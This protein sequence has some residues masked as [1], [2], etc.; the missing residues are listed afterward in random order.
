MPRTKPGPAE[1]APARASNGLMMEVLTLSEAAAYLRLPEADVVRLV[2]EQ[3]LPARRLG[4]EWRF[5]QTA[6]RDRLRSGPGSNKEAWMALAGV[7]K[8]DP[9]VEKEL[10]EIYQRRRQ[11]DAEDEK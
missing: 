4:N 2:K 5:L 1:P 8:D 10:E 7:W 9:Y 3:S 11:S 6:I